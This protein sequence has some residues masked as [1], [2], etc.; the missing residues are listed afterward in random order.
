MY[1][2]ILVLMYIWL[3][4]NQNSY[5]M[6]IQ[7]RQEEARATLNAIVSGKEVKRFTVYRLRHEISDI[8]R[9]ETYSEEVKNIVFDKIELA[10]ES[11]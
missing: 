8:L 4:T 6:S 5:K 11:L 2:Y 10:E 1:G 7:A 3:F 9:N